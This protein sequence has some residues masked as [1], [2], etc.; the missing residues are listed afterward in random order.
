MATRVLHFLDLLHRLELDHQHD[1]EGSERR[2]ER[3]QVVLGLET[4]EIVEMI[5]QGG[6]KLHVYE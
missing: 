4:A 5:L 1:D 6:P 3:V 2:V